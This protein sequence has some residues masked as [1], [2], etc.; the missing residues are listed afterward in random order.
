[1]LDTAHCYG[2]WKPDGA[3]CSESCLGDYFKRNGRGDWIVITKGGHPA[4]PNY[5]RVD[6]YL[7]PRRLAADIDD[8]LGHLGID[9]IDLFFL[10]RDDPS[11]PVEELM[12]YLA[13]EVSRGRIRYLGASNWRCYR[14]DAANAYAAREGLPGL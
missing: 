1:V 9:R 2:F 13:E 4:A 14:I 12:D 6:D 10:H 8:S 7:S 5:R 3:G 11:R